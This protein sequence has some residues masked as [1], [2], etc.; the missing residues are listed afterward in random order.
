MALDSIGLVLLINL[1]FLDCSL[2]FL[3]ALHNHSLI[4]IFSFQLGSFAALISAAIAHFEFNLIPPEV[5]SNDTS[6]ATVQIQRHRP[7]GHGRGHATTEP[8]SLPRIISGIDLTMAIHG[9]T[10]FVMIIAASSTLLE[11]WIIMTRICN[12]TYIN[13]RIK[14]FLVFVSLNT[15]R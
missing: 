10:V 6:S 13:S 3:D 12:V 11:A 7:G 5:I 15:L 8:P 9:L 2:H 4:I 14:F 1:N